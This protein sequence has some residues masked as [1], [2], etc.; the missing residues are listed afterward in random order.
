MEQDVI[1]LSHS[2]TLYPSSFYLQF[3]HV[4]DMYLTK[5]CI[6]LSEIEFLVFFHP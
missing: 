5:S 3:P 4:T 6:H 1:S 2:I